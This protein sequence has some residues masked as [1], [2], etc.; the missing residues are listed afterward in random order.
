MLTTI[1]VDDENKGRQ[2]LQKILFLL[3]AQVNIIGEASSVAEAVQSINQLKP[4][5]VFL[6]INLG[7]GTGFDV[8]EQI[9][10]KNFQLIFITAHE[11][12]ALKA[13]R[14]S[15]IDYITKPIDPDVLESAL[16]KVYKQNKQTNL[17]Q[18]L[19]AL[20]L[21]KQKINKLAL[22]STTGLELVKVSEIVRC[23]SSNNYTTFY[24]NNQRKILVSKTLKEYEELLM[25]EGFFRIHQS[26]LINLEYATGYNKLD[27]GFVQMADGSQIEISRRKKDAFLDLLTKR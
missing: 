15:A 1:I 5:L 22:P 7:D 6:D 27:G 11:E 3:Q 23:E 9:Q 16:Q 20:F 8:L 2:T 12:F 24:L 21:N 10:Y 25:E 26:H 4:E 19:E 18:K 17:E 14:Y 13:F